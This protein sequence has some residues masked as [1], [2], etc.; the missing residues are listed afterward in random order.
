MKIVPNSDILIEGQHSPAGEIAETSEATG[1]S[2]VAQ[3]LAKPAPADGEKTETAA[4]KPAT[5]GK[6]PAAKV[7]PAS[8]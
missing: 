4:R 7:A 3:G 6:A 5:G 1:K 8:S 2:L